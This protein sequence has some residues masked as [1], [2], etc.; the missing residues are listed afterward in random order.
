[1]GS[2]IE[3]MQG[4]KGGQ[5]SGIEVLGCDIGGT[6]ACSVGGRNHGGVCS[7]GVLNGNDMSDGK[8]F[9]VGVGA[10]YVCILCGLRCG[11]GFGLCGWCH[12]VGF[13]C[14]GGF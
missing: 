2:S 13:G 6:G 4:V 8:M 3:S 5:C 9:L 12:G 11:A 10:W 7:S 1:M 14:N